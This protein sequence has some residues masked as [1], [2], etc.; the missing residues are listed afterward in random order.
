MNKTIL[1]SSLFAVALTAIAKSQ[2][3]I[4]STDFSDPP[5]QAGLD[6]WAGTDG[7]IGSEGDVQGIVDDNGNQ[8][9][10]LGFNAPANTN[11][12]GYVFRP[13]NYDPVGQ[14]TP[15]V[16][17]SMDISIVD[18]ANGQYDDFYVDI[19]NAENLLL[20][21]IGFDN[22]SLEIFRYDRVSLFN[23][24]VSFSNDTFYSVQFTIDFASNIWSANLGPISLFQGATFNGNGRNLNLGDITFWWGLRDQNAP[25]DNY[26]LV[27]N[28][29]ITGVPEPG[30]YALLIMSGAG[31]LW[32]ARRKRPGRQ[33]S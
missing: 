29:A 11:G 28:I 32:W 17:F 23:T 30:T 5:F 25:G 3:L 18:S 15:V 4:Y 10:F 26:M 22:E 16:D 33:S 27:D 21:S 1:L 12:I 20:G 24:G 19:Y 6:T 8:M 7:W 9:G 13:F 31:A 14:G 2:V